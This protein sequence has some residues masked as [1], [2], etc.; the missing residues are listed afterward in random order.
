MYAD[1]EIR[2][3]AVSSVVRVPEQA[4]LHSGTR[5]VV[6]VEKGKGLFE[7]REVKLGATGGGYREVTR[8]LREGEMLVVSSQFLINSESNL[9]EAISQMLSAQKRQEGAPTKPPVPEHIH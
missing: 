7:P 1:V 6:I 8:G 4:I 2:V 3:P 5:S 9:K